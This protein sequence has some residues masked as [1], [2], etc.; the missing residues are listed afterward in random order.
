[1]LGDGYDATP[2][3]APSEIAPGRP[4][5]EPRALFKKL[6]ESVIEEELDRMREPA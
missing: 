2:R 3:W 4:L 5:R 6:D 1:M